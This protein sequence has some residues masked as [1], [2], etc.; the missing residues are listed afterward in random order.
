MT[1]LKDDH[2]GDIAHSS[3]SSM[4][5][6]ALV[7][8]RVPEPSHML[9][10]PESSAVPL[11]LPP[12]LLAPPPELLPVPLLVLVPPVPLP[13][14]L[15]EEKLPPLLEPLPLLLNELAPLLVLPPRPPPLVLL[16]PPPPP[17]LLPNP[18]EADQPPHANPGHIPATNTK[19]GE[20]LA[21]TRIVIWRTS[22]A[23]GELIQTCDMG[24]VNG[25]QI[26]IFT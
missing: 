4:K 6:W 15:L 24:N 17:L 10:G 22:I 1:S 19:S 5:L 12:L 18:C 26:C 2:R 23:V 14:P 9:G 25:S 7:R 11:L 20:T 3:K 8:A 13:L 16:L 21:S